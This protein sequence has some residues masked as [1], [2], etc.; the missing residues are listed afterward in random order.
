MESDA[1]AD[2]NFSNLTLYTE[3]SF[4]NISKRINFYSCLTLIVVG[5]VA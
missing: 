2:A 1:D 4:Y 5:I 3:D